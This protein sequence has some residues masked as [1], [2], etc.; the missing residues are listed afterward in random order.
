MHVL[1]LTPFYP[2]PDDD[3]RGCFVAEP[4]PEL[5]RLG[6]QHS[7]FVSRPLQTGAWRSHVSAAA[8]EAANFFAFPG[9]PGLAS[10]GSFLYHSL[11]RRVQELHRRVPIHLLHAHAALP[12]GV[13]AMRLA[14]DLRLPFVVTVH[15]LDTYSRRQVGGL[16][17]KWCAQRSRQVYQRAACVLCVSGR[18]QEQVGQR[19]GIRTQVVYNGVDAERF[20]LAA[21]PPAAPLLLSIGNLIP[22]KGHELVLRATATLRDR[23]PDIRCELIGDGPDESRLRGLAHDLGLGGSVSFLGRCSRAQTADA[24]RRCTLFV[25]PS[26]YEGLGCVYLEAMASGKPAIACRG[27]GIDEVIRS[28]ENGWLVEPGHL[29]QIV[30][31][32]SELLHDPALC[33]RVGMLARRTVLDRFTLAHQAEALFRVYEDALR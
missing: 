31:I 19:S 32:V 1:T 27:Q 15:G 17:G 3:A 11:R 30:H 8:A 18:V 28:G 25:L 9:N 2:G 29:E 22:S 23:H 33:D 24:L 12:C 20:S 6:V 13:A 4:L 5:A 7:V 10:A 16:F 21:G 14:D 26:S